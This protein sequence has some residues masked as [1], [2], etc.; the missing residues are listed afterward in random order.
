M[1]LPEL[2]ELLCIFAMSEAEQ[3]AYFPDPWQ[4]MWFCFGDFDAP[5]EESRFLA[6]CSLAHK[7]RMQE[8]GTDVEFASLCY[9]ITGFA[10]FIIES[11]AS[12]P[13]L[14]WHP[15][16]VKED[17]D[18]SYCV[19][20]TLYRIWDVMRRLCMEALSKTDSDLKIRPFVEI[21]NL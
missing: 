20:T 2:E 18:S 5:A 9:E 13:F 3:E 10:H 21:F 6:I 4:S 8:V 11:S 7:A 15:R 14:M 17:N 19:D 1:E 16:R 12:W